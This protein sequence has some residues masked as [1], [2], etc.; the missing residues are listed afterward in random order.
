MRSISIACFACSI[1]WER[2][3]PVDLAADLGLLDTLGGFV[4]IQRSRHCAK[5]TGD[6]LDA[7]NGDG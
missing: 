6:G 4:G 1:A 5:V 2:P 3:K 7:G